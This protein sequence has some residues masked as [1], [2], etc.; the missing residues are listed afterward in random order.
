MNKGEICVV[1][2]ESP[3]HIPGKPSR[4][5]KGLYVCKHPI[6]TNIRSL[7]EYPCI[8]VSSRQ[9]PVRKMLYLESPR[10]KLDCGLP[11]LPKYPLRI[12]FFA[13][14]SIRD[15]LIISIQLSYNKTSAFPVEICM[16]PFF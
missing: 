5:I 16:F 12:T 10:S 14:F 7:L 9:A 13:A 1:S 2:R 8:R 15:N 6:H 4:R 3:I 11:F